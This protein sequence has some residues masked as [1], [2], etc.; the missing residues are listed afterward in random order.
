[1]EIQERFWTEA[2]F[3]RLEELAKKSGIPSAVVEEIQKTVRV[4]DENYGSSRNVD[5]DDGGFVLLLSG[6]DDGEVQRAYDA[7]LEKYFLR[8]E[9]VEFEDII[10]QENHREWHSDLFL[11]GSEYTVVFVYPAEERRK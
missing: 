10:L 3:P 4:L 1:M 11:A 2:Q 5:E 9:L 6:D 8:R 7:F